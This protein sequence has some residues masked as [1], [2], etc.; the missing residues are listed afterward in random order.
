MAALPRLASTAV[1][2][3]SSMSDLIK[4]ICITGTPLCGSRQRRGKGTAV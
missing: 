2:M 3:A 4:T 1:I